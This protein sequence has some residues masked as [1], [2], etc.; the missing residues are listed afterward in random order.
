MKIKLIGLGQC[1]SFV[2]YD[3]I[4][5][6]FDQK[7]SR[8]IKAAPQSQWKRDVH[9]AASRAKSGFAAWKIKQKKYFFGLK[10]PDIP[11]FYVI[12]GNLKNAVVDGLQGQEINKKL[13]PL[14]V[15]ITPLLL[16]NRNNGCNLGQVGE[17]VFRKE[18]ELKANSNVF[19]KL[20]SSEKME[21]NAL[22]FA[23]GGGSGSGGAPVLNEEFHN[24]NSL[25]FNMMVLPPY[26]IPDHRQTWNTGRCIMRL[27]SMHTQTG[28]LLFSNLSES[29][30]DQFNVNQYICNLI[31]RLANFGYAGS[32]PKVAT[33]LDRKDLQAFFAGKPAF[34]GMSSLNQEDP[35]DEAIEIMVDKALSFRKEQDTEG[36]SIAIPEEYERTQLKKIKTV[37]IVLGLPPKYGGKANIVNIV[38]RKVAE[39][40]E[41]PLLDL[42]CRAY[43]YTSPNDVELT[44]FLRHSSFRTNFLLDHFLDLYLKWHQEEKTEYEYLTHKVDHHIGK[45]FIDE[46]RMALEAEEDNSD[47]DWL[48][49]NFNQY[50]IVDVQ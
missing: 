21:I 25:L 5:F 15:L 29:L 33:D 8:E 30:N 20:N 23:G 35:N 31:V 46:V 39:R 6:L 19:A 3:V 28:L 18:Q 48:K 37:M 47:D 41:S 14:Q 10:T 36:L 24:N 43:S 7:S 13:G 44:I 26:D 34:V 16:A 27:A 40:L 11:Q 38:K 45:D 9:H 12:D 42:D 49:D 22:V 1:G 4:A 50:N 17:Y 32:V 2:V